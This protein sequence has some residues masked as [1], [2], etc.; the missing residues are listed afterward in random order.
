MAEIWPS[1]SGARRDMAEI[2][3]YVAS[4][5][6]G[7][8][9]AGTCAYDGWRSLHRSLLESPAEGEAEGEGGGRRVVTTDDIGVV[10]PF[11]AQVLHLR[12]ALRA[13]N[14]GAVRVGTVVRRRPSPL[15]T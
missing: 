3:V 1:S 11:R 8:L 7:L 5:R 9:T 10:T 13:V 4:R 12:Q 15:C 2:V 6:G 14:L